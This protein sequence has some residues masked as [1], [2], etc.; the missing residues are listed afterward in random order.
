MLQIK[1]SSI[2]HKQQMVTQVSTHINKFMLY[3][4][5]NIEFDQHFCKKQQKRLSSF[6]QVQ[7]FVQTL[8]LCQIVLVDLFN[9]LV[10]MNKLYKIHNSKINDINSS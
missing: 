3:P 8:S 9:G 10:F 4:V 7:T 5:Q 6:E 2:S 1:N